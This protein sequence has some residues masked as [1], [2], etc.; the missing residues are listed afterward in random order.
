MQWNV[1]KWLNLNYSQIA[2]TNSDTEHNSV[3]RILILPVI[4][5]TSI[6]LANKKNSKYLD[7]DDEKCQVSPT[8][9]HHWKKWWFSQIYKYMNIKI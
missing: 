4:E 5:H 9:L 2:Y 1:F 7:T 3:L 8:K 6:C